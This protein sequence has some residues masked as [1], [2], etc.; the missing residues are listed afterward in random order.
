[1]LFSMWVVAKF[2]YDPYIDAIKDIE[3]EEEEEEEEELYEDKYPIEENLEQ[4]EDIDTN[5]FVFEN[6]PNG[7]VFMRYNKENEDFEYWCDDKQILYK[8]LETVSRKF[9]NNFDCQ[10][11][12]IDRKREIELQKEKKTEKN[13]AKSEKEEIEEEIEEENSV[14]AKLKPKVETKTKVKNV[15]VDVAIRGNKYKYMDKIKNFLF[16]P[17]K[18]KETKIKKMS[19]SDW[20]SQASWF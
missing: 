19:F 12:Y 17:N 8:Y 5:N 7:T 18:K 4:K 16:I 2:V 13:K 11:L 9:V 14:F 10:D 15:E 20:K 1:M 3:E 6:T